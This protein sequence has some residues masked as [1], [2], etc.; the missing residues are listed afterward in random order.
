MKNQ[1]I[2]KFYPCIVSNINSFLFQLPHVQCNNGLFHGPI[3]G[4]DCPFELKAKSLYYAVL[5]ELMLNTLA[6][7]LI[8]GQTGCLTQNAIVEWARMTHPTLGGPTLQLL[9]AVMSIRGMPI[10]RSLR[11]PIGVIGI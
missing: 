11:C 7:G 2:C 9:E 1:R 6:C 10:V 3:W 4:R 5:I 8:P